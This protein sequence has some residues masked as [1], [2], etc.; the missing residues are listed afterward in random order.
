MKQN[1]ISIVK[2]ILSDMDSEDVNSID[3]SVEALQVASIVKDTFNNLIAT[4][5][6]PETNRLLKLAAASD[7]QFP[8][9]FQYGE[10]V[11]EVQKV[12]YTNRDGSYYEV[13]WREPLDF[14]N[15]TDSAYNQNVLVSYDKRAGTTLNI[16]TDADPRYYT[17]FDQNWIV[18]DSYDSLRDNSLQ[19]SKTRAY[20]TM[21][22]RFEISD[23]YVPDLEA[24]MFPYLVA[25]AKSTAMSL[26]KGQSDPKVEQN[27][28]RQKNYIQN[29]KFRTKKHPYIVAYGRSGTWP[30]R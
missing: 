1:L 27:A 14:L 25:E 6:V 26:L 17:S 10:D 12:W 7:N 23:H 13:H 24:T 18:M 2:S 15:L 5:E 28:R 3:D 20:G 22:P 16:R 4:R 30:R 9:H 19:E 8:T 11:K 21:Y 29:D